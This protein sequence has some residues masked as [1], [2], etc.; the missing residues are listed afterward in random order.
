[1]LLYGFCVT[2][3]DDANTHHT[4]FIVRLSEAEIAAAL[5]G[6][7]PGQPLPDDVAQ[8]VAGPIVAALAALPPA[9][10]GGAP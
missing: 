6:Y 3:L 2:V 8:A 9:G 4:E 5:V 10:A 1:M 7:A